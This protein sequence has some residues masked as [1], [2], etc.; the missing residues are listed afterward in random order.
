MYLLKHVLII[1]ILSLGYTFTTEAQQLIYQPKHPAF[2][3]HPN[4]ASWIQNSAEAQKDQVE[5]DQF[6]RDPLNEFGVNMQR[7]ILNQL[8]REIIQD[9]F[10]NLDLTEEGRHDLGEYIVEVIPGGS[11]TNIIVTDPATGGQTTIDIPNY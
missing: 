4:N 11:G 3:G 2:G 5:R 9:R 10:S 7:Q 1:L 6:G 8:S